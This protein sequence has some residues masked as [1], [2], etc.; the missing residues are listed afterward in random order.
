MSQ[1]V[2]RSSQQTPAQKP[3][4]PLIPIT[5]PYLGEEEAQA[6]A[7]AIRTGW[8]AQGP[9]VARFE[10]AIAARLGVAH[11]VAT[12]NC[13]TSL[14]VALLCAGIGP[15]DEVICPSFSFIATANAV[16]YTGARPVFV[17]IDPRTY[18]ID[19]AA[20]EAAITPRTKAI[21]PVDQIGLAADLDAVLEIAERYRLR[22]IEDAAP[23]LGATYRGRPVGAISPVTC[24]SFHPRKSITTGE[25]GAIATND[26]DLAARARVLRS[27]GASVS[28]LARHS[29]TSVIIEAY[30]ELG[31]NYRMT[32]IQAA[33]GI[34]QL[35]K[36][37]VIL[38]RR[39]ELAERYNAR[40]LET[41]G[42]TPPYAPDGAPHTYQSYCVRLDFAAT[43]PRETIME[44]MLADGVATRRGVMAIHEEPYYVERFGRVSLP[45]T[46]AATRETLLLPL[47]MTMTNAEQDRVIDALRRALQ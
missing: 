8:I 38:A 5:K 10:E 24:F 30:E 41:P 14:H 17:E 22:V 7:E 28:D 43:P 39:R 44:R 18:N 32:D 23:A 2:D 26:A 4:P 47:Y 36:L 40:L 46:E 27:H 16:L 31:Y 25:G 11:V 6:A 29:A 1:T 15:G 34:E 20:I 45:V 13:T 9:L 37:D 12:S 33:M 35:K 3:T 42:A 19:P 21:I